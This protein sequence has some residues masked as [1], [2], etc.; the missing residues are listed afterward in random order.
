MNKDTEF[1]FFLGTD[2]DSMDYGKDMQ[3]YIQMKT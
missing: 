1:M 3:S 2:L